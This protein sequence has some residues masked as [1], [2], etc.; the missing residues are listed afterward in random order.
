[1]ARPLLLFAGLLLVP[2]L[3]LGDITVKKSTSPFTMI[4]LK[5]CQNTTASGLSLSWTTSVAVSGGSYKLY[6]SNNSECLDKSTEHSNYVRTLVDT[7][8]A[9]SSSGAYPAS[10]TEPVVKFMSYAG[11]STCSPTALNATFIF[12]CV[13]YIPSSGSLTTNAATGQIAVD[14]A[15]PAKPVGVVVTPGDS[16]LHVSWTNGWSTDG[17]TPGTTTGYKVYAAPSGTTTKVVYELTGIMQ[18]SHR[19]GGLTNDQPY[20]VQVT[21]ITEGG[22][23]SE[24]SDIVSGTPSLVYDFW[25]EY[26]EEGGVEQGGCATGA[27]GLAALA[28]LVPFALRARRRRQ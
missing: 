12:F 13:D 1:M 17:G 28:G 4:T 19:I 26:E 5:E 24:K 6:A 10:G 11:N 27:A 8:T 3:T 16:G 2:S 23:E 14:L 7:I 18:T 22:N 25:R 20:D 9:T 21:A 15:A